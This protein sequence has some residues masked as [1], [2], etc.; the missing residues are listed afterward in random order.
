MFRP[1]RPLPVAFLLALAAGPAGAQEEPTA[2]PDTPPAAPAVAVAAVSVA[3]DIVYGHKDGMAL[4]YD[5][6]RPAEQNGAGVLFMVS[7]GWV[8]RWFPPEAV[9]ER[10]VFKELLN[11]GFTVFLVRHGSSPRYKVPDAV[12]DVRKA[13]RHV[14]ANAA[15]AGIDPARIGVT[16][17]SAGGH[18]ALMLGT[19]ADDGDPDA[20]PWDPAGLRSDRVAAVVAQFPPVDLRQSV[21]PNDAFPALDFPAGQAEAVSPIAHVTADDA[22]TLLIHGDADRLVK[23]DNS[24]RIEA[25]FKA[26]GV[27]VEL[28]VLEG[29]AHGFRGADE[30]R[31]N[32][33]TA[34][35]FEK[36]L[37]PAE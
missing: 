32:E 30:R 14:R 26:A 31:A 27:P 11:R 5:V 36:Y 15:K 13:V 21:G 19:T 33:L 20:P 1:A 3:A 7:G 24:E 9:V 2:E 10:G 18:L 16:G 6:L 17:G 25:A 35:W 37:T 28:V 34:D 23:L 12:A 8:S 22:P 4:T 29:A